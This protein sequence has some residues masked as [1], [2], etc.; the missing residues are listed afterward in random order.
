MSDVP[1]V[2]VVIVSKDEPQL[3]ETLT[4]LRAHIEQNDGECIVIDASRRRLEAIRL[5]YPWVRWV[6]YMGPLGVGVTIAHQ[7]NVGVKIAG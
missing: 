3:A 4:A 6:D 5:S 2:S 7:R 1:Q